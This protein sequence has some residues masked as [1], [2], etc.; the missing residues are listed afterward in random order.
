MWKEFHLINS[1][2]LECSFCGPSMADTKNPF[3]DCHFTISLLKEL[4]RDFAKTLLDY[5]RDENKVKLA[6]AELEL[7]API[8]ANG[9]LKP[10]SANNVGGSASKSN[11]LEEEEGND[12]EQPDFE[13]MTEDRVSNNE[14][15]P[16]DVECNEITAKF[17]KNNKKMNMVPTKS[18]V[19]GSN[20]AGG[21]GVEELKKIK[22]SKKT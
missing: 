11:L 6:L 19:N 13:R 22:E 7:L 5:A 2:T 3:N 12:E 1:F 18:F 21:V 16:F 4:G 14:T 10:Q 15:S 17:F 8:A 9:N 20:R